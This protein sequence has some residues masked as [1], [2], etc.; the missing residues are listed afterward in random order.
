LPDL[1][2]TLLEATGKKQ[3]FC[4]TSCKPE[5]DR[6][7][8]SH[9]RAKK[10]PPSDQREGYDVAVARAVAPCRS[11]P[12]TPCP[13]QSRRASHCSKRPAAADE[14]KAAANAL[15]FWAE[16]SAKPWR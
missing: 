15:E 16:K 2:L 3:L 8:R 7:N 9:R 6:R 4:S 12:N 11:W 13:G 5:F 14:I 1:R 10:R